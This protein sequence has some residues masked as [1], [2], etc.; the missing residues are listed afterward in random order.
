MYSGWKFTLILHNIRNCP[1]ETGK[2]GLRRNK[3]RYS[4]NNFFDYES[5]YTPGFSKHIL[6]A[7]LPHNI[8]ED[9]KKFAKIIHDKIGCKGIS[10]TD[11]IYSNK[12]IYFLEINSH[13]GL[14]PISLLPEQLKYQDISFDNL[15]L[16]K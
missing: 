16:N 10:R 8:Y 15:I 4:H 7:N 2:R 12:K 3:K 5:K 13:P 11:F 14:T 6:P 9:C 1:K